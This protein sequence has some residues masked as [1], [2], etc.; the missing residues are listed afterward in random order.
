VHKTY[1]QSIAMA[2]GLITQANSDCVIGTGGVGYEIWP[3]KVRRAASD[4]LHSALLILFTLGRRRRMPT[5][6][7]QVREATSPARRTPPSCGRRTARVH[8][9]VDLVF[10]AIMEF[11]G[12]KRACRR[13]RGRLRRRGREYSPRHGL[14]PSCSSASGMQHGRALAA[15][16][17]RE[18]SMPRDGVKAP[19][20]HRVLRQRLRTATAVRRTQR[21]AVAP[22]AS[23]TG[24][25]CSL[26]C[27]RNAP[28]PQASRP[29]RRDTHRRTRG[30]ADQ[31][32]PGLSAQ[33][34]PEGMRGRV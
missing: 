26:T 16:R 31:G 29:H 15:T 13:R 17:Y 14:A 4:A 33:P 7:V 32:D 1:D 18:R 3:M 24:S 21:G 23:S 6:A 2:I 11:I 25:S 28:N 9:E 19:R 8:F 34:G 12:A 22:R 30:R 27:A 10:A 5:P 20:P